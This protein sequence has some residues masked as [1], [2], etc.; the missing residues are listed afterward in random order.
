MRKDMIVKTGFV[1]LCLGALLGMCGCLDN[2]QDKQATTTDKSHEYQDTDWLSSVET[3][4]T[5]VLYHMEKTCQKIENED[6]SG[7]VTSL[8]ALGIVCDQALTASHRHS[9]S[10]QYQKAKH[11]W[12]QALKSTGDGA[13]LAVAGLRDSDNG[14]LDRAT[15]LILDG[16]KHINEMGNA[17]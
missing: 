3:Y 6:L 10:P 5:Q 8:E 14:K 12:E 17:L 1:V 16:V 7:A 11:E 2:G 13:T 9:V 15:A 4:S